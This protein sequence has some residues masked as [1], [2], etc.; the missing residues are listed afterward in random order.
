MTSA[1]PRKRKPQ[2]ST[3]ERQPEV[4]SKEKRPFARFSTERGSKDA[5]HGRTTHATHV[6]S[7]TRYPRS[8]AWIPPPRRTS[9]ARGRGAFFKARRS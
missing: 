5:A 3:F 8:L 6:L 7:H 4:T 2:T 9:H 1:G